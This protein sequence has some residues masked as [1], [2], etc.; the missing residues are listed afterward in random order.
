MT[1]WANWMTR[2]MPGGYSAR[3]GQVLNPYGSDLPA[4]GSSTGSGV[5]VSANLCAAAIGTETSGSILSPA[6]SNMVVG[7]KPTVGLVSR[8]GVI[9][10]SFTQDTAGPLTRT[11][12]DGARVLGAL[13]GVDPQDPITG[14]QLG[15]AAED[16]VQALSP[17][18]L[19]DVRIG[20]PRAVFWEELEQEEIRLSNT[21]LD[22]LRAR[23]A[24]VVD[25]AEITTAFDHARGAGVGVLRYEF[26]AALNAYLHSLGPHAPV[27]SLREVIA[28]NREHAASELR[29]GQKTL[30]SSQRCVDG[31]TDPEYLLALA[32]GVRLCRTEGIDATLDRHQLDA[33]LFP[34][35]SGCGMAARAGY[36]SV[37][38]PIGFA[39]RRPFGVTFTG[40]AFSEQTLLRIA[41]AFERA[42]QGRVA[43]D[44][45]R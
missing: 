42:T 43:P 31:L 16:Y 34:G 23:G 24:T 3:G 25:P 2:G 38:V 11:V 32:E 1:E 27:R 37:A 20:V 26:R 17:D 40:T 8:N 39:G 36:P 5:A 15:K 10:I 4:G 28:F 33:L 29:Y 12:V 19:E 14:S 45:G 6:V 35:Y 13:T 44:L 7:I 18:A 21:V 41:Y 30:L 22:V 9:P